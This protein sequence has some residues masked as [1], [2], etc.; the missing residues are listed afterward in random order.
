MKVIL[1]KDVKGIGQEGD[2]KQVADGHAR[3][4]LLPNQLAVEANSGNMTKLAQ[5]QKSAEK[6]QDKIKQEA[7][8]LSKKLTKEPLQ[9]Q[10]KAGEGGKLFGAVTNKQIAEELKHKNV[11]VD[12]RKIVMA[13]PI[14]TLGITEVPIKLHPEVTAHLRV[15]VI[16]ES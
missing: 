4:Y 3:N 1:L 2:I 6:K 13:E 8:N 15:E 9:V 12:K 14:R 7:E 16:E 10:A 11:K 5:V